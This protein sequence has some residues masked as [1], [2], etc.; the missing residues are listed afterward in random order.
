MTFKKKHKLGF[1]PENDIPLDRLPVSIKL[2]LGVRDKV[3]SIPDWQ[4]KLRGLIEQWV[5][6]ELD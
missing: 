6:D 1:L 5:E 4:N 3:R 2:R